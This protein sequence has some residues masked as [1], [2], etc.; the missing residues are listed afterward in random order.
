MDNTM[1]LECIQEYQLT[2]PWHLSGSAQWSFAVK[3]GEKWFIKRFISPKYLI[4][5]QGLS[6]EKVNASRERCQVF[7]DGKQ[8]LYERIRQADTGNLVPVTDFFRWE[9]MFYAVSPYVAASEYRKS[10]LYRLEEPKKLLIL[11]ILSHCLASL[12]DNGIVHG[13]LKMD[14]IILKDFAGGM[15]IVKLIDFDA[16][17]LEEA[18]K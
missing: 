12:H 11:K 1:E 15:P 18:P 17:F 10:V 5:G 13:D 8:Q 3:R 6:E 7:C 9:N 16:S 2:E 14:N 4:S